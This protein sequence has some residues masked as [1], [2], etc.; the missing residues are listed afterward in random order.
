MEKIKILWID[1]E[2]ESLKPHIMFLEEHNYKITKSTNGMDAIGLVEAKNF[3]IIILDEMMPGLDGLATLSQIRYIN[4]TVPIIMVTKSEEENLM[5]KAISKDI[6]DYIIKP[7]NPNQILMSIKKILQADEIKLNRM[8]EEYSKFSAWLNRTLF[9]N[10]TSKEWQDIYRKICEWDIIL[11]GITDN[12]LIQTHEFEKRNVNTE[13]C[14]YV[15]DN[16]YNWINS[17]E[18]PTISTDIV[19]KYV[20]PELRN[21]KLVYFIVLDCLRFDQLLAFKPYLEK[22][23][24]INTDLYY[25][26]LPT[27][28]PYSRNAIFSGLMPI[29]IKK[30]YP[31]YWID[32]I[33]DENSCNRNEHQLIDLQLRESGITLYPDS[34]YIK[35]FKIEEG[36][37][38]LRKVDSYRKERLV[39]LVYNFLDLLAHH[40]SKSEIL[41]EMMPNEKALRSL[42]KTWFLHSTFYQ[43]MQKISKQHNA[44][45]ILTTDHGSIKVNRATKAI[46]DKET[47]T[48]LRYKTGRNLSSNS[49]HSLYLKNPGDFKLPYRNI[50]QNY[51]FAKEDYY[52]IYPNSFHE[53]QRQ[54][55]G[56]FQHGG[57][58]ME[59][60][61]L[62]VSIMKPKRR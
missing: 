56:T 54:Y 61:I 5:D 41:Q 10:P 51:I 40:R 22:Y 16:Y 17:D 14:N 53:Y 18:H 1:D 47:T 62:P 3:D 15:S 24:N 44:V 35:I 60:M 37:F 34:K 57:I 6:A 36:D 9:S 32:S 48:T 23:F 52:F 33:E 45:V 25:S 12:N 13:F 7:I 26:I 58:S 46:G 31:Q 11:D 20:S 42:T 39:I 28:T 38:V 4:S 29:E 43:V 27:A 30:K 49:R 2:I 8:G 59:E 21:N 55:N 19:K 50:V